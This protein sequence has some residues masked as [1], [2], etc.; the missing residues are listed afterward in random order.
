MK[1]KNKIAVYAT[2]LTIGTVSLTGC[3]EKDNSNNKDTNNATAISKEINKDTNNATAISKEI[4]KKQEKT[5]DTGCH[6]FSVRKNAYPYSDDHKNIVNVP[7]GYEIFDIE[8]VFNSS[9][10]T[11]YDV[12]YI[13]TV[14]VTVKG[15]WNENSNE[16]EYTN[17][18]TPIEENKNTKEQQVQK[19][20]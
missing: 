16:Y 1:F 20:K 2:M 4:N 3:S 17:F 10:L 8:Y 15:T 14:P 19:K 7:N 5:F 9:D 11:T 13:N 18:G 12:W 6:V